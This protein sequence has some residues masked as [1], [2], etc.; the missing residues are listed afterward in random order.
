M[1]CNL[2]LYMQQKCAEGGGSPKLFLPIFKMN[3]PEIV[4]LA[5][6]A[7]GASHH[8]VFVSI[9]KTYPMQANK[10]LADGHQ[11]RPL[12]HGGG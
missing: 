5:L 3:F 4:D 7:E 6:P 10:S 2:L 12:G 9:K 1:Q 8:L 11:A